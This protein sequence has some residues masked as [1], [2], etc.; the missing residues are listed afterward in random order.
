MAVLGETADFLQNR[1]GVT[2]PDKG[3]YFEIKLPK[4]LLESQPKSVELGWIDFYRG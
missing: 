4:A 3:G 2:L 1:R